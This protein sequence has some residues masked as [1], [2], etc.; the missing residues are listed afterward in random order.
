[1]VATHESTSGLREFRMALHMAGV[2]RCMEFFIL[3]LMPAKALVDVCLGR[4]QGVNRVSRSMKPSW[5]LHCSGLAHQALYQVEQR[6]A[7]L[8][9]MAFMP[10]SPVSLPSPLALAYLP[11]AGC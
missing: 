8:W 9:F 10:A 1:M 7:A 4:T 11:A 3:A 2:R 6:P 5:T